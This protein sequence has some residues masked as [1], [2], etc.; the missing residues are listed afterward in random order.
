MLMREKT[1]RLR[2]T[3][4]EYYEFK[5]RASKFKSLSYFI[6]RAVA[7]FSDIS[8]KDK[9]DTMIQLKDLWS[10]NQREL[11][12]VAGNLNQSMKRA[13]E[14]SIAGLLNQSY[15]QYNLQPCIE[16]TLKVMQKLR[17]EETKMMKILKKFNR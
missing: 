11:A 2:V 17:G 1:I 3:E 8:A 16:E 15:M 12:S 9:I 6:R 13:N 7:E 14:L 10:K 5:N 4:E